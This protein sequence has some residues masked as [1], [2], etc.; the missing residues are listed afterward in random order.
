MG[1]LAEL[2]IALQIRRRSVS[3]RK[4]SSELLSY[5]KYKSPYPSDTYHMF[6]L[7]ELFQ[8]FDDPGKQ[9]EAEHEV[10]N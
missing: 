3:Q 1:F 7:E 2:H 5:P 8:L 9:N 4:L 6:R 10:C